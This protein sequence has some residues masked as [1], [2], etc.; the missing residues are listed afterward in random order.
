M[1]IVS[2]ADCPAPNLPERAGAALRPRTEPTDGHAVP[3]GS[4][5]REDEDGAEMVEE[6]A[7]R[8]EV[9]GVQD[10]GRQHVDEE[11]I[12]GEG[13]HRGRLGVEQEESDEHS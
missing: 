3:D 9:A 12:G 8:H 5:D 4:D 2:G 13:G 7:V 6:Q 1:R 11:H 10:D